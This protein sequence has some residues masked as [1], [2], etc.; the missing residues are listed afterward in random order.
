MKELKI[1]L[2]ES[3]AETAKSISTIVTNLGY[4]VIKTVSNGTSAVK[5]AIELKPDLVLISSSLKGKLNGVDTF[6]QIRQH[7][8]IPI[9]FIIGQSEKLDL[10]KLK[11]VGA[12]GYLFEPFTPEQVRCIIE[13]ALSNHEVEQNL[14]ERQAL[15][16]TTLKSIG[17][18]VIT[19]D[20][21]GLITFL[22]PV[23]EKLTGWSLSEAVG[24]PL[25]KVFNIINESTGKKP[26]NPVK[27]I[28]EKGLV[29]ELANHTVLISRNGQKIPID[30]SGAPIRDE[31]G[32][33][34]GAVLVFRDIT[35]QRKAKKE[36]EFEKT[37]IDAMLNTFPDY[38]YFKDLNSRFYR[39]SKSLATEVFGLPNPKDAIGKSD[40]DFFPPEFAQK[41]YNGEQEI[42]KTGKPIID[43]AERKNWANG[44]VS[45][46]SVTK[47]PLTD[48]DGQIIG[49]FGVSKNITE[50]KKLE[51]ALRKSEEKY[52]K[53][54][55][56][57]IDAIFLADADTGILIDCNKAAA[58]LVGREKSEII[59]QHQRILHPQSEI[60]NGQSRTYLKHKSSQE[61]QILEC[62]VITKSGE[63]RDVEIKAS[64]FEIENQKVVYGLF[65]DV[66]EQKRIEA[67]LA[68]ER[69]YLRVL[70]N[71]TPDH[72]YYKDRDSRFLL[73]SKSQADRF[74]LSDPKEAIGKTDFDFFTEEHARPAFEDEQRIIRTGQ[75]IVGIEEKETWPDGGISW[76][77]TTKMP[78]LDEK[79][80]IIGTFGISRDITERK[81]AEEQL[82]KAMEEVKNS[83]DKLKNIINGSS[84][85]QFFIDKDHKVVYWNTALSAL[86]GIKS[87]EI[88]GTS[89][90]WKAFYQ[91]QRPCLADL[92]VEGNIKDLPEWYSDKYQKSLLIENGF[93]A[94]AFFPNL[95]KD[96]KWLF[97]TAVAIKDSK[98]E[99]IGS[100]E[101]L[102]D[103]TESKR[104]EE[105]LAQEKTLLKTVI[106]NIPDKIYAKDTEG[107]FILCNKAVVERM[108]KSDEKE[109]IGK[110][111]FDFIDHKLANQFRANELEIIKTGIPLLN[112]EEPLDQAEGGMRWNSTTKVPLRD[113]QGNIIGIVGVG[114]DITERKQ[115]EEQREKFIAE[116]HEALDKI[117]TL[118][119]LIPI[120]ACCKKIRDDQ[121]YWNSVESYI[122][123]HAEVEFT[124]GI[125]PDCMK[126]LYPN[127]CKDDND[128]K[129]A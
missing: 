49:T 53:Q 67:E 6:T 37:L 13:L 12:N 78:L 16:S 31:Y 122:K 2:A 101:T 85:P 30:D 124:H 69:N 18:A 102:E 34:L 47:I 22:N 76:V 11:Q 121:G 35:E 7:L 25:L 20:S 46:S 79:G 117:K 81:I 107:R 23:A 68:K 128:K 100:L 120:C 90:H 51:E 27:K 62:Q 64:V 26:P 63:I 42:I 93:E 91:E 105:A 60:I 87:E 112:H 65:H 108:G 33:I 119:G 55:E 29:I 58:R 14:V 111:D 1:L 3:N 5:K 24:K 43:R 48:K 74:G 9:V 17:D 77:S 80:E 88:V 19:T 71:T 50:S 126:K 114:R 75:P 97:F 95:G 98:G 70:L 115:A 39:V 61:G 52:R 118:K 73:M 56:E 45:W 99:I 44:T 92:L 15:L 104:A 41:D 94:T 82:L 8:D 38:I 86:T 4:Q 110:T 21:N 116:L 127:Y 28:L 129:E 103:I 83:E 66:T 106:E 113:L 72:I 84:I 89:D 123:D 109:I 96:G 10:E 36:L 125:C 32:N 54:F 40:F 57:N 59:G